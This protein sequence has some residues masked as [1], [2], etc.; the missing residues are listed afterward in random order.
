[1]INK[2]QLVSIVCV[3]TIATLVTINAKV[4]LGNESLSDLALENIEALARNEDG[5]DCTG[6]FYKSYN[7]SGSSTGLVNPN[8][9][10]SCSS[11]CPNVTTNGVYGST[12]KCMK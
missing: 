1:M 6:R 5:E 4:N 3:V 2:R 11:P 7:F 8:G 12:Y 9:S 10:S